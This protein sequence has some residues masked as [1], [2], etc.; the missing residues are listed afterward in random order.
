[1]CFVDVTCNADPSQ[2]SLVP[3]NS[4]E[5]Q[6]KKKLSLKEEEQS[7][8]AEL[9][10]TLVAPLSQNNPH[11]QNEVGSQRKQGLA[12]LEERA[13]L[14]GCPVADILLQCDTKDWALIKKKEMD[15]LFQQE[16]QKLNVGS[17]MHVL[18]LPFFQQQQPF[19]EIL[20]SSIYSSPFYQQ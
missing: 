4:Q 18:F 15:L 6:S 14:S 11:P 5:T 10:Q 12:L 19:T 3:P 20:Q 13:H 8:K 7:A 17:D 2:T 16:K 1:M 9:R